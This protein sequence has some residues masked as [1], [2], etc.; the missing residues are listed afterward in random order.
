MQP[1]RSG[2]VHVSAAE[3]Q[4][5]AVCAAAGQHVYHVHRRSVQSVH[6]RIVV[7]AEDATVSGATGAVID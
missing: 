3:Q 5:S 1:K 6:V 2:N 4:S 7:C